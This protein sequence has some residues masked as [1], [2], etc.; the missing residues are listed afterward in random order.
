[1][2]FTWPRR[3][4]V[5][6]DPWPGSSSRPTCGRGCP[7]R[8]R[9]LRP[10]RR[11]M[12]GPKASAAVARHGPGSRGPDHDTRR[13]P[14]E[15]A[16]RQFGLHRHRSA[17]QAGDM[18]GS[19]RRRGRDIRSRPRPARCFSTTLHSTGLEPLDRAGSFIGELAAAR[20][21]CAASGIVGH[22]RSSSAPESPSTPSRLNS[23]AL[24]R[25]SS[26]RRNR[27]IRVRNSPTGTASLSMLLGAVLL[28]D[29]PFDRQAVAVPARHVV[30][31]HS[32]SIC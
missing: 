6:P 17:D 31:Y 2:N 11:L 30:G 16:L 12:S 10:A 9:R 29:L 32:R 20:R 26:A 18:N 28:L 15:L 13:Q 19:I 24:H 14:I 21:R 22:G 4:V 7:R 8:P 25:R 5:Q 3:T 23:L 27:G 1:M